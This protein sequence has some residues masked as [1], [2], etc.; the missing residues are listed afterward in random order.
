[1]VVTRVLY[2]TLC[3]Q[4]DLYT[5]LHFYNIL[6][7]VSPAE[8]SRKLSVLV[9]V[10]TAGQTHHTMTTITLTKENIK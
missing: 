2:G 6:I 4:D 8:D 10:S 1:M 3:I 7:T 9:S 5:G